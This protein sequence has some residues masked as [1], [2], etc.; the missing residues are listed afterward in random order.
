[1]DYV[2]LNLVKYHGLFD[3]LASLKS[4]PSKGGY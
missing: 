1:M 2:I 4:R 3:N